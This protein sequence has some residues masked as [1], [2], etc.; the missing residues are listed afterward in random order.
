MQTVSSE[1]I[2]VNKKI[3]RLP[4]DVTTAMGDKFSF[5]FKLNEHTADPIKVSNLLSSVLATLDNE[6]KLLGETSNGD[7]LQGLAMALAIRS[8]I[9]HG[10]DDTTPG[11]VKSLVNDA[12]ESLDNTKVNVATAGNA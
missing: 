1:E 8:K 11:L 7:V 10:A 9:I 2:L 5:N 12:L 4:V 3:T 6:I